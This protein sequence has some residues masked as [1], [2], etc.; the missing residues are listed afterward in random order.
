MA[1]LLRLV[2]MLAVFAVPTARAAD[3][4]TGAVGAQTRAARPTWDDLEHAKWIADGR[5]DAPRKVY[6][7]LDANCVYCTKFW[8]DTRPWVDSGKVQLRFLLVAVIAPTSPGKAAALLAD[9]DPARRLAAYE[10]AH[11]FGVARAMSGGPHHSFDD[12][13]LPPLATIPPD[14]RQQL[15]AN[16]R[17]MTGLALTGTPGV[18]WRDLDGRLAARAGPSPDQLPFILG[19]P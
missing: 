19:T 13:N 9:P 16:E 1:S 2:L 8:S 3:P 18:A 7:F 10:R 17:L 15:V 4:W 6:V 11:A 5:D 12:P 14:I